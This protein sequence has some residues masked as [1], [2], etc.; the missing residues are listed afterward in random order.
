MDL[1]YVFY[2]AKEVLGVYSDLGDLKEQGLNFILEDLIEAD[3]YPTKREAGEKN[4]KLLV[5]LFNED[6]FCSNI[7]NIEWK[8][9]KFP[10]DKIKKESKKK[11]SNKYLTKFT[12]I[13]VKGKNCTQSDLKRNLAFL[14]LSPL[15]TS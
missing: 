9:E 2:K 3:L 15:Y 13:K 12:K 14:R 6:T 1:V 4:K 8:I 11:N 7:N 10:L 5:E